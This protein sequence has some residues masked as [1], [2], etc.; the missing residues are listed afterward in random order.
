MND[1]KINIACLIVGVAIFHLLS[2]MTNSMKPDQLW[3]SIVIWLTV[4]SALIVVAE[5]KKRRQHTKE[6]S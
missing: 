1:M 2:Y 6:V 3:L 5:V 4:G